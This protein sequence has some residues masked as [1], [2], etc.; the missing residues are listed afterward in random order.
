MNTAGTACECDSSGGLLSSGNDCVCPFG[1]KYNSSNQKCVS[2]ENGD[3]LYFGKYYNENDENKEPIEWIV[4]NVDKDDILLM[5]KNIL[6]YKE[7]YSGDVPDSNDYNDFYE[8]SDVKQWLENDFFNAAFSAQE[9]AQ[10]I[11]KNYTYNINK[12][13]VDDLEVVSNTVTSKIFLPSR[14]FIEGVLPTLSDRMASTT[15][16]ASFSW[17]YYYGWYWLSEVNISYGLY[18]KSFYV[19]SITDKGQWASGFYGSEVDLNVGVRPVITV[20]RQKQTW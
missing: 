19:D 11:N 7:Y 17:F 20:K 15:P 1:Y 2:L 18:G 4:L 9:I 13:H 10:I 8:E 6:F 16:Y 14:A 5:S 12:H 3:T